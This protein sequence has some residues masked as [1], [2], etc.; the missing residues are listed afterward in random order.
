[1]TAN[2]EPVP[3]SSDAIHE[4]PGVGL[5]AEVLDRLRQV[6][7]ERGATRDR[8]QMPQAM[9]PFETAEVEALEYFPWKRMVGSKEVLPLKDL[10]QAP[11]DAFVSRCYRLLL[12]REPTPEETQRSKAHASGDLRRLWFVSWLR[13]TSEGRRAGVPLTDVIPHL[14]ALWS[15]VA[16][17]ATKPSR[18]RK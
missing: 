15:S 10:L 2:A 12:G 7:R 14:A 6:L 18:K 3:G 8:L 1:V 5:E 16:R 17:I 11:A 9:L 13:W 4:D